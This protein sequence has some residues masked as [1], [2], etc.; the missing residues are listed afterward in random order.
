MI[1]YTPM[2]LELVLEGLEEMK[3]PATRVVDIGGVSMILEDTGPAEGKVARLLSTNPRDYLRRDLYP[4]TVIKFSQH[5]IPG[6]T[7]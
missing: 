1:L 7:D 3:E 2:Q 4:G 6:N 5:V